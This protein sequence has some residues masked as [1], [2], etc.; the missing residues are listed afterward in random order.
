M[1]ID[2]LESL[3]KI[4]KNNQI[5]LAWYAFNG[6]LLQAELRLK[7]IRKDRN[8]LVLVPQWDSLDY[9]QQ[10]ISGQGRINFYVPDESLVFISELKLLDEQG[11]LTVGMP[12]KYF[13]HD[14]RRDQRIDLLPSLSIS[15]EGISLAKRCLDI[16]SGGFSLVIS[17]QERRLFK[18]SEYQVTLTNGELSLQLEANLSNELKLRPYMLD[19]CPY[20]GFR[21]AFSFL[22]MNDL[23]RKR[24]DDLIAHL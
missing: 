2:I 13:L 5:I 8:D 3:L 24:L 16:S 6:H 21:L 14:R 10:L 17:Q 12:E 22:N 1:K 7:T 20:G 19:K 18:L 23:T 9:L 15:F 11:I 4:Q